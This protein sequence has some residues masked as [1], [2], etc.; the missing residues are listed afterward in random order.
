[1]KKVLIILILLASSTALLA[2]EFKRYVELEK[3]IQGDWLAAEYYVA[4]PSPELQQSIESISF[5]VNNIVEWEYVQNGKTHKAKGRY[6]IYSFPTDE[7]TP[8][9]LPILMVAP[10]NY[11]NA[12]ISSHILLTLSE[13]E[14]DFDSRFLQQWGKLI[15]AKGP[16]GKAVLFIQKGNKITSQQPTERH[17]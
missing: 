1:M 17:K 11:P 12:V 13:V 6:G 16:G 4:Q 2:S 8:R 5:R 14:L 3:E 9:Q 10:T 15:K 7:R